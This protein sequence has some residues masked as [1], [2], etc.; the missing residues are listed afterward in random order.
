MVPIKNKKY[1]QEDL[2]SL[3]PDR[4]SMN[5]QLLR[6]FVTYWWIRK[7]HPFLSS[8]EIKEIKNSFSNVWIEIIESNHKFREAY[9]ETKA[10]EIIHIIEKHMTTTK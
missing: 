2:E 3:I 4:K 1:I 6:N 8:F 7:S 5:S 9:G 10:L